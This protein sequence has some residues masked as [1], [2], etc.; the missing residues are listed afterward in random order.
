MLKRKSFDRVRV[1]KP[2]ISALGRLRKEDLEFEVSLGYTERKLKASLDY[3]LRFC[4]KKN[5]KKC[6]WSC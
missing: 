2:V 5:E 3:M 4:C 1:V 6:T